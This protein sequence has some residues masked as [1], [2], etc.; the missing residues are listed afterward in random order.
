M[1]AKTNIF[2]RPHNYVSLELRLVLYFKKQSR[3][4]WSVVYFTQQY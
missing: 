3:L 2:A 4:P 1:E